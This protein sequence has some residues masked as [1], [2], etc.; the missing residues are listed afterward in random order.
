M[1]PSRPPAPA[2]RF[3]SGFLCALVAARCLSP[4]SAS[5]ELLWYGDP[6]KGRAVFNNVNL[7]GAVRHSPGS[8]SVSPAVDAVYGKIWRVHKPAADKRAEIR[9]ATG[10]SNHGG[11]GGTIQ[12]GGTYYLG[13]RYKFHMPDKK[14]GGWACFQWKSYPDPHGDGVND[15]EYPILMGYDGRRLSLTKYG[16]DWKTQRSQIVNLWSKP[17]AIDTWVDIVLVIKLSREKTVG[18]IEFYFNGDKQELLTGGTRVYHN[19]MDAFEVSPKWGA[20]NKN[21]IGTEITVD[22]AD[23]RIGTDLESVMPKRATP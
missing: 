18:Y 3:L 15:Q 8:G 22:I 7:E 10:F 20:Y 2:R 11:K 19:T 14:M 9:G 13:W 12:E 17:V 16:S 23:L 4:A 5:A 1:N 6:D 21:A